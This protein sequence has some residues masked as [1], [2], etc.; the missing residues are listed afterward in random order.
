MQ[1]SCGYSHLGR[2]CVGHL[3]P[4]FLHTCCN[5]HLTPKIEN[6]SPIVPHCLSTRTPF[7]NRSPSGECKEEWRRLPPAL[8]SPVESAQRRLEYFCIGLAG[9][10]SDAVRRN[11]LALE[12]DR[13]HAKNAMVSYYWSERARQCIGTDS[14]MTTAEP[15]ATPINTVNAA[16]VVRYSRVKPSRLRK[17]LCALLTSKFLRLPGVHA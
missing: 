13:T 17:N 9:S 12:E 7:P 4:P 15:R 8:A 14:Y 5:K 2:S 11:W 3:T 6:S 16:C 10:I 1:S